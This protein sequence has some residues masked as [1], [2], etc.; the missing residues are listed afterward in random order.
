MPREGDVRA[1][2]EATYLHGSKLGT[3]KNHGM[4]VEFLALLGQQRHAKYLTRNSDKWARP[5]RREHFVVGVHFT[6]ASPPS[7]YTVPSLSQTHSLWPAPHFTC[8]MAHNSHP[9][10]PPPH[11][12]VEAQKESPSA[13]TSRHLCSSTMDAVA[14]AATQCR[15][16]SQEEAYFNAKRERIAALRGGL[17]DPTNDAAIVVQATSQPTQLG[18][19]GPFKR[20]RQGTMHIGALE[21]APTPHSVRWWLDSAGGDSP[22]GL[23]PALNAIAAETA[24]RKLRF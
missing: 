11:V 23:G 22:S 10:T 3:N 21:A 8:T 18:T 13:S 14:A 7:V 17:N 9:H 16:P 20:L 12:S 5:E 15:C 24:A 6:I 2:D 1:F 19:Q 4:W